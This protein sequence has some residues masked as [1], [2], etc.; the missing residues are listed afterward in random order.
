MSHLN[1]VTYRS[2]FRIKKNQFIYILHFKGKGSLF[3]G[4]HL[5]GGVICPIV[6]IRD[7]TVGL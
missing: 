5:S 7:Y 3:G 6:C 4:V 1:E 2:H